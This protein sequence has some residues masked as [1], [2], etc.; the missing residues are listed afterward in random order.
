M[1]GS[2]WYIPQLQ[3]PII[4][5]QI[6]FWLGGAERKVCL[7]IRSDSNSSHAISFLHYKRCNFT[8]RK[9]KKKTTKLPCGEHLWKVSMVHFSIV[10]KNIIRRGCWNKVYQG[11]TLPIAFSVIS[12]LVFIVNSGKH[13]KRNL[14]SQIVWTTASTNYCGENVPKK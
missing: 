1:G 8:H 14:C 5:K 13:S 4:L 10:K 3:N 7:E 11:I 9:A 12:W 2:Q 6:S